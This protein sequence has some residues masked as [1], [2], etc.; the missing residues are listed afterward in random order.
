MSIVKKADIMRTNYLG[1]HRLH[2]SGDGAG[3]ASAWRAAQA[4]ASNTDRHFRVDEYI[5][6]GKAGMGPVSQW[7]AHVFAR[8]CRIVFGAGLDPEHWE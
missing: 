5:G 2:A 7:F 8:T 6:H 1:D 4:R 3:S